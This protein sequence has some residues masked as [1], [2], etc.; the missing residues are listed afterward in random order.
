VCAR[1]N[2]DNGILTCLYFQAFEHEA[3]EVTGENWKKVHKNEFYDLCTTLNIIR[4]FRPRI[5]R[6]VG[7]YSTRGGRERCIQVFDGK[8]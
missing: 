3:N 8:L 5:M 4:L 6:M 2:N 1:L 7:A